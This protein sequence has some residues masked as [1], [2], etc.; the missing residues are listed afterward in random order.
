MRESCF[1]L[2]VRVLDA[3][4]KPCIE[5]VFFFCRRG[6]AL[7]GMHHGFKMTMCTLFHKLA[8]GSVRACRSAEMVEK[9]AMSPVDLP[10]EHLHCECCFLLYRIRLNWGMHR[11]AES[12][13]RLE[14]MVRIAFFAVSTSNAESQ[15]KH[16]FLVWWNQVQL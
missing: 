6:G 7:E 12:G 14:V 5:F 11:A 8:G 2:R 13:I 4:Q 9:G 1:I 16:F 15:N 10:L 3:D